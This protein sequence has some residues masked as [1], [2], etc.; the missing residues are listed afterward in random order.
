MS[1]T[2]SSQEDIYNATKLEE[3]ALNSLYRPIS[4]RIANL[5]NLAILDLYYNQLSGV[6][7]LNFG[8]LSK[9]KLLNL[10][11]NKKIHQP[12]RAMK[13]LMGCKSLHALLLT[14]SFKGEG[15]PADN[16][17]AD[18]DGFQ[19]P[20]PSSLL[21]RECQLMMTWLILKDSKIFAK[22]DQYEFELPIF[23]RGH[24]KNPSFLGHKLFLFSA[25]V[26][27]S[28]NNIVG[29]IPTEIGQLRL[30]WNLHLNK[31]NFSGVIPDQILNLKILE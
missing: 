4:D 19:N 24:A 2:I 11:F 16:D 22:A 1:A 17:M 20:C 8:K 26:N 3:L 23:G 13:I 31:N 10:D 9:L 27:L 25:S 28:D 5:T 30:L 15:I 7:P 21:V 14:G 18:L 6:L 29:D 12:H